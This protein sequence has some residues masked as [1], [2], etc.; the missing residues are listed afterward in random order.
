MKCGKLFIVMFK[1][2]IITII[3]SYLCSAVVSVLSY[4]WKCSVPM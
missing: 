4:L 3:I 1:S 2:L